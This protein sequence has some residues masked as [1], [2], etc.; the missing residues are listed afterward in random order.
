VLY[1]LR[2][3]T[4]LPSLLLL[5][6][7]KPHNKHVVLNIDNNNCFEPAQIASHYTFFT[8]VASV[9]VDK[10]PVPFNIFTA[11]SHCFKQFYTDRNQNDVKFKLHTVSEEYIYKELCKLNCSKSTG[12]ND[13]PAK[14]LKDAALFVKI[15]IT[16]LV[17]SSIT[18]NTV[19]SELKCAKVKPLFKKGNKSDVPNYRP[20]S[21]LSI[22]SKILE[23]AVY[24][25]LESFLVN[26][27]LLYEYQSGF[28]CS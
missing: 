9:L 28:R 4:F 17:N 3:I 7:V 8:T 19:P 15:H 18:Y 24:N 5:K 11:V 2:Y 1:F 21:I 13:I 25:Q 16:F 22:V 23:R 12:L 26:H 20:V 6:S 27:G 10:L 14:Y